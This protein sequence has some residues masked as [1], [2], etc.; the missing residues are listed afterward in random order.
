[1]EAAERSLARAKRHAA[2]H[3]LGVQSVTCEFLLAPAA[4]KEPA[5]VG[6]GLEVNLENPLKLGFMKYHTEAL[7]H[8]RVSKSGFDR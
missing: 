2:L 6:C 3:D 5:L 4:R 8:L 7:P 1:M